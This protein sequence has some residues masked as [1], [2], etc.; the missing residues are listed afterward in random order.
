MIDLLG[1]ATRGGIKGVLGE[2]SLDIHY[3]T[4]A[5]GGRLFGRVAEQLKHFGD[6]FDV[7]LT[8]IDRLGVVFEVVVAIWEFNIA[9]VDLSDYLGGV[10]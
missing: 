2:G 9:L 1:I 7:L 8:K 10:S 4:F 3:G 5:C 6:V